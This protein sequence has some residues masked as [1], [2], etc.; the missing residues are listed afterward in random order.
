MLVGDE[1]IAING[2]SITSWLQMVEIIQNNANNPLP[3][4]VIRDG[5]EQNLTITPQGRKNA[6][7][8]VDGFVGVAPVGEPWPESHVVLIKYDIVESFSRGL[9]KTWEFIEVSFV[10]IGKLITADI[11]VKNLSGPIS[12]AQGAGN[13]ADAGLVKFLGFLALI[14]VNLGV[15]N[16]LPLPILDGGHLFYYTIELIRGKSVSERAQE[17]GFKFGAIVLFLLMGIAII[18]DITRLS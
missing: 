18:N 11:S 6:E 2:E 16:L 12:I 13:S 5:I 17:I 4:T 7:G 10:M 1:I 9:A 8:F 3:F 15:I 14:S